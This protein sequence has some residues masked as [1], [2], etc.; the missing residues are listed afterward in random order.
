[1]SA[2]VTL[3]DAH[4]NEPA[5]CAGVE[6]GRWGWVDADPPPPWPHRVLWVEADKLLVPSGRLAIQFTLDGYPATPPAAVPWDR[7]RNEALPK[8]NWPK[9]RGNVSAVFKPGWKTCGLYCPCDR[10][11]QPRHESWKSQVGMKQWWWTADSSITLYLE[12]IHRCLNPSANG[13]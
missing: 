8:D 6:K 12:F 13:N 2:D 11:A 5:F 3:F 9:G 4:L 10:H 7:G 1:M